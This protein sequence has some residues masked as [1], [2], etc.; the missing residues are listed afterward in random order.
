MITGVVQ[1]FLCKKLP[2]FRVVHIF[3]CYDAM[4][5]ILPAILLILLFAGCASYHDGHKKGIFLNNDA[6]VP[7]NWP[8]SELIGLQRV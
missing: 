4:M 6:P 7:V 3:I 8:T 1:N 2:L 5:K